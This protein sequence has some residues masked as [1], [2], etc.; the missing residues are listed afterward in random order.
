MLGD[1]DEGSAA[2]EVLQCI[3][4]DAVVAVG[5]EPAMVHGRDSNL[6]LLNRGLGQHDTAAAVD[7]DSVVGD[8]GV[9]DENDI[10]PAI[11]LQAPSAVVGNIAV[12]NREVGIGGVDSDPAIVCDCHV[13]E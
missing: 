11:G 10:G 6:I 8:G 13:P 4:I 3:E 1:G 9:G 2:P 12:H 5:E 7:P